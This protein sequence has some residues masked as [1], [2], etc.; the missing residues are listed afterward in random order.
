[1]P[2]LNEILDEIR[3]VAPTPFDIIRQNYIGRLYR[4]TGRNVLVY[5]S[6]WLQKERLPDLHSIN[7]NDMVGIMNAAHGMVAA[8]AWTLSF[9]HLAAG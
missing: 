2:A 4:Q 1:M 6:G 3:I 9:I 8:L 7:D 5:Y